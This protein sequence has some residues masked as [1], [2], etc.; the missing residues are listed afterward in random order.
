MLFFLQNPTQ[1]P[2]LETLI[3]IYVC[4]FLKKLLIGNERATLTEFYYFQNWFLSFLTCS[5]T[6]S[7]VHLWLIFSTYFVFQGCA[8]VSLA[9]FDPKDVI[10]VRWYNVLSFKFM[11][12]DS[13]SKQ[14]SSSSEVSVREN[15]SILEDTEITVTQTESVRTTETETI[16]L[17]TSFLYFIVKSAKSHI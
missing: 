4:S 7:L 6:G 10:S 2:S 9:D 12:P 16:Q 13:N 5:L 15:I 8:S 14:S 3:I 17:V 1:I 11:Q